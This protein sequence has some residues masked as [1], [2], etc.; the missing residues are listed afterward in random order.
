[1]IRG[2]VAA[3]ALLAAAPAIA[4]PAP[5]LSSF[6]EAFDRF[7]METERMPERE[8]VARFRAQFDALVPGFYAPRNGATDAQYA[9]RVAKSLAYYPARRDRILAAAR[10]FVAAYEGGTAR[11]RA[12]FPD[13][14]PAM[15]IYLLHSLGEMDGGTRTIGGRE[16]AV[17]GA[18]VIARIHDATTIGPFLDHELFHFYNSAFFSDCQGLWCAVWREGLAVYV[19]ARMNPAADD[20]ALMLTIPRPMRAEVEPRLDE[21]MCG[22]KAQLD[23]RD[24]QVYAR[25]FY[26]S[27]KS[28]PFPPRYGYLLGY[29]LLQKAGEGRTLEALARTPPGAARPLLDAALASYAC[30]SG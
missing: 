10:D 24:D 21:A 1:M 8:R 2:L 9:V 15:P 26:G 7:A 11:F 4:Q 23:S 5:A 19:A 12:A 25:Y 18:D 6:V 30:R 17:F 29:L 14:A 27:G 3:A 28:D 20:R 13:Y 22:L 16:V